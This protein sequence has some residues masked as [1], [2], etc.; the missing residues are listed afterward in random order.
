MDK[1][2][3][4]SESDIKS[5]AASIASHLKTILNQHVV[6]KPMTRKEVAVYLG[7]SEKHVSKLVNAGVIKPH[8]F[9]DDGDPRYLPS[10]IIERLKRS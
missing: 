2:I 10:E 9:T 3:I 4:L 5:L 6:E 8:R 1:L 7:Y